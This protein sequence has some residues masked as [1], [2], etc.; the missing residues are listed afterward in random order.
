MPGTA[1]VR[2]PVAR[3]DDRLLREIDT[4]L[5]EAELRA[6]FDA[7]PERWAE[8][9]R[10]DFVHVFFEGNEDA[11]ARAAELLPSLQAGATRKSVRS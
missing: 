3:W 9:E 10:I 8:P 2:E 6:Y 1:P 5:T 11:E 4:L 7:S